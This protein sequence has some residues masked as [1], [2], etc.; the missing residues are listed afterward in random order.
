MCVDF[1][2]IR[3]GGSVKCDVI[4]AESKRTTKHRITNPPLST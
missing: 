4:G 3:L 1:D 2:E